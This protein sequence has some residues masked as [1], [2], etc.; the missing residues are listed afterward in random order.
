MRV[1]Y[2][3]GMSLAADGNWAAL[4]H[5]EI[6]SP[7]VDTATRCSLRALQAIVKA[8]AHSDSWSKELKTF[9]EAL[10]TT[11][12]GRAFEPALVD[13]LLPAAEF[14]S[15]KEGSEVDLFG[16]TDGLYVL[17]AGSAEVVSGPSPQTSPSAARSR[18]LVLTIAS[19]R[20]LQGQ[21][22]RDINIIV[23]C[24][25]KQVQTPVAP[26]AGPD[27][28]FNW[29]STLAHGENSVP[30]VEFVV[31]ACSGG[32]TK[33]ERLC[34]G[35]L[36]F[37]EFEKGSFNGSVALEAQRD[38]IK[39]AGGSLQVRIEWGERRDSAQ[40]AQEEPAVLQDI[41][42]MSL[43]DI[44]PESTFNSPTLSPSAGL[45]LKS[46]GAKTPVGE[47]IGTVGRHF[48]SVVSKVGVLKRGLGNM[49]SDTGASQ[50]VKIPVPT[51]KALSPWR[52]PGYRFGPGQFF[53]VEEGGGVVRTLENCVLVFVPRSRLREAIQEGKQEAKREQQQFLKRW[54]PG[55]AGLD[56]RV[57][58]TFMAAF[59]MAKFPRGRVLVTTSAPQMD[60]QKVYIIRSGTCRVMSPSNPKTAVAVPPPP[61]A[62]SSGPLAGSSSCP[63]LTTANKSQELMRAPAHA[64]P[65]GI[66][67]EGAIV[68][69][70]SALFGV[71]EPFMVVT[72]EPVTAIC[73][74]LAERP[75]HLWPKEV[76][77]GLHELMRA[78]TD[79]HCRRTQN[80]AVAEGV[81]AKKFADSGLGPPSWSVTKSPFLRHK[82]LSSWQTGTVKERFQSEGW[83]AEP[84]PGSSPDRGGNVAAL[85]QS[86]EQ[87]V[88]SRSC[89]T[90]PALASATVQ[91]NVARGTLAGLATPWGKWSASGTLPP[92]K[93]KG[94]DPAARMARA[95]ARRQDAERRRRPVSLKE[96]VY[97][98]EPQRHEL[99]LRCESDWRSLSANASRAAVG[100]M[101]KQQVRKT[102]LA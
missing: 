30:D 102:A 23:H 93:P 73:I 18:P 72:D 53:G 12:F 39:Q 68:G 81:S 62:G 77:K 38:G 84:T 9:Q 21:D 75:V 13:R 8:K 4:Q 31:M 83:L 43:D 48:R 35:K 22:I 101:Y 55:A 16:D 29:S 65:I 64:T 69:Y 26:G 90:L 63:T 7:F 49:R 100:K 76:V 33:H 60:S 34:T 74:C 82:E 56:K 58:D 79:W 50:P 89:P 96:P 54:M 51:P 70:A 10:S 36:P 1:G 42:T 71:A 40:G 94:D 5:S 25:P 41:S 44:D 37:S 19:A 80:V 20:G 57:F 14:S 47:T 95:R 59:Q 17:I 78:Q 24:G 3:C 67:G 52:T 28:T 66:V 6:P 87:V 2:P 98:V 46:L 92:P 99:N 86:P 97:R 45:A 85:Q 11:S 32:S 15:L 61:G 91:N 27:P 88:G